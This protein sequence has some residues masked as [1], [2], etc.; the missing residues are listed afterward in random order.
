MA[1]FN[2][3][4][5][6]VECHVQLK[7]LAHRFRVLNQVDVWIGTAKK[8]AAAE[9][10]HRGKQR[11][12][13]ILRRC[14]ALGRLFVEL[15]ANCTQALLT[16]F[17]LLGL[18]TLRQF[19]L[20]LF[21]PCSLLFG[22]FLPRRLLPDSLLAGSFQLLRLTGCLELR[23]LGLFLPRGLLA[24]RFQARSFGALL[25][26]AG[27]IILFCAF[28]ADV[29]LAGEFLAFGVFACSL[30]FRRLFCARGILA[31]LLLPGCFKLRL[32]NLFLAHGFLAGGLGALGLGACKLLSSEFLAFGLQAGG[33]DTGRL[34]DTRAFLAELFL[35]RCFALGFG[36]QFGLTQLFCSLPFLLELGLFM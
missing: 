30:R 34:F 17:L 31:K 16:L 24:R 10:T 15:P 2:H 3:L 11:A 29:F 25:L 4:A 5:Q 33:F 32:F 1:L 7:F 20:C 22:R 21:L 6:H 19:A 14:V 12:R 36:G 13:R 23:L 35:A 27:Q 26:L 28:P 8:P 18:L 9:A